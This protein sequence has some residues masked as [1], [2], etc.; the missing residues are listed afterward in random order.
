[1]TQEDLPEAF[2]QALRKV[3]GKRSRIVV[4]HILTHGRITTED[5]ETLYGYRHPP[6]A[7]R[8]VREQGIPIESY[9]VTN[10]DGRTIAA[11]RFGDPSH[12][13]VGRI[14]GRRVFSKVFKQALETQQKNRCAICDIYFESRYLQVDHRIPY[15]VIGDIE[16]ERALSDYMV[17]CGSCNRAKSWSCEHCSNWLEIKNPEICRRCYWAN[18]TDYDHVATRTIRRVDLVWSEDETQIHDALLN[19]AH[20]NDESLTE[21]IKKLLQQLL[22]NQ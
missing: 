13:I 6:R 9:N 2:L 15:E 8:D 19:Q 22:K 12:L 16:D 5:L 4:D 14:G 1:M 11:Y 18:P 7:I 3:K 10:S 20:R 21:Y 17:L